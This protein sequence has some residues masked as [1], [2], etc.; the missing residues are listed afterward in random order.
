MSLRAPFEAAGP[1]RS[2][3]F[4]Q[5]SLWRTLTVAGLC[6]GLCAIL[7]QSAGSVEG[8]LGVG[9]VMGTNEES[10][11]D[12]R[13]VHELLGHAQMVLVGA[14]LLAL[15]Q[16]AR[17]IAGPESPVRCRLSV[18]APLALGVVVA[19]GLGA[20]CVI[21]QSTVI[22]GQR[23][24]FIKDDAM[25]SMVYARHLSEGEGLS[26]NRGERVE[27]YSNLLWVL[28][29]AV[30]HACGA[31][32]RF[33][34]LWVLVSAC[35]S[36]AC[37]A[38][39]IVNM[40]RGLGVRAGW[41]TCCALLVA[42]DQN[43][44]TWAASGLETSA[45]TA[46]V[47]ASAWALVRERYRCFASALVLVVLLRSDG[48]LIASA[49]VGVR[50]LMRGGG[51]SARGTWGRVLAPALPAALTTLA[52]FA[53]RL[54][55]YGHAFPNTYYLKMLTVHDRLLTGIAGYGFRLADAY[56]LFLALTTAAAFGRRC[57]TAARGIAGVALLHTGYSL[58]VGGDIFRHLRFVAPVIPL[59]YGCSTFVLW[60]I[61]DRR[62]S[63]AVLSQA[64][65]LATCPV[66]ATQGKLGALPDES[67]FFKS[68]L[69]LARL[70]E[71][72]V[73]RGKLATIYPAGTIPWYAPHL[74]YLD[75]FGKNDAHI[76]H[77]PHYVGSALGHNK[78]DFN[79]V[80]GER[81][82]DVAFVL[83]S[84]DVIDRYVAASQPER[85]ALRDQYSID[86]TPARFFDIGHPL[87]L[88]DYYPHRVR[89]DGYP[90]LTPLECVF[91]RQGS[92]VPT[93]W[94]IPEQS[95]QPWRRGERQL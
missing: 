58:Y 28:W 41:S 9:N 75:V 36:V 7:R 94:S 15:A 31:G 90:S 45:L 60:S 84:C 70:F 8:L 14:A 76:A 38:Y 22:D 95:P 86:G 6:L 46:A 89:F 54:S 3:G 4:V 72:N 68:N 10:G 87:F 51:L 30:I 52:V 42:C 11:L 23:F 5:S 48:F 56:P 26:Y 92:G 40:L 47:T 69:S 62:R 20:Y 82:P 50:W 44:W 71:R 25:T 81:Q 1:A 37:T 93:L 59:M 77:L 55:Y 83:S 88:R 85:E 33:A 34:P 53:F 91:V 74:R 27:G 21:Q 2:L 73:P 61:F 19:G 78:F 29:M 43:T 67:E 66:I 79:Y 64:L 80:Y 32:A 49:L 13:S 16:A 24:F 35:A 65:L 17:R 57:P 63:H 18:Y 12:T 39:F